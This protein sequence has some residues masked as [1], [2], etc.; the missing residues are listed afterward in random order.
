MKLVPRSSLVTDRLRV[1]DAEALP[2]PLGF[3]TR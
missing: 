1:V 3:R 2:A